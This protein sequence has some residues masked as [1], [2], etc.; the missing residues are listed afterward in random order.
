MPPFRL[1]LPVSLIA[2]ASRAGRLSVAGFLC[3]VSLAAA[4]QHDRVLAQ[5]TP[6]ARTQL[7]DLATLA[8]DELARLSKAAD[9]VAIEAE[10]RA[11]LATD[12]LNLAVRA[13]GDDGRA[14]VH[15]EIIRRLETLA[16]H[17]VEWVGSLRGRVPAPVPLDRLLDDA[18]R[19]APASID[20]AGE[21]FALSTLWANGPMP[22]LAPRGGLTGPLLDAGNG[23]WPSLDGL[24]LPG[25]IAL[26]DF[27]GGRNWERLF[28]LGAQAVIVIE[29]DFV[30]RDTAERLFAH[31]P[32]PC[33]RYYVDRRTGERLRQLARS[34]R[35]AATVSG[36]ARFES[37][38]WETMFAYLPPTSPTRHTVA[39]GEL[40]HRIATDFGL[41]GAQLAATAGMGKAAQDLSEGRVINVPGRKIAYT[42]R[43]GDLWTRLAARYG[44]STEALRRANPSAPERLPA[45]TTL[46]IPNVEATVTLVVPIDAMSVATDAEHGAL[47]AANLSAA[48]RF[49]EHLA[50]ESRTPRRKGLLVV[51]Q[52]ADT[53]GGV[54]SRTLAEY[55]LLDAG[56]FEPSPLQQTAAHVEQLDRAL[57]WFNAPDNASA[58][59][60]LRELTP[61]Q[62]RW[63]AETWLSQRLEEQ[64]VTLAEARIAGL[65]ARR[66]VQPSGESAGIAPG[67]SATNNALRALVQVR[68]ETL[69]AA[70]GTLAERLA[71]FRL[72]LVNTTWPAASGVP[73]FTWAR[74]GRRLAREHADESYRVLVHQNN[75]RVAH[76]VLARLHPGRERASDRA[77]LGWFLDLTDGS[78]TLG[79]THGR[80][81]EFRGAH[82]AATNPGTVRSFETRFSQLAAA[83][84]VRAGWNEEWLFATDDD[85]RDFPHLP[86]VSPA[87]YPDLWTAAGVALLSLGTLNDRLPRLD[88]PHDVPDR[89]DFTALARQAR[90]A[91]VLLQAGLERPADSLAPARL[92]R[93]RFG[94]L[95]GRALQFNVRSGID[96]TEPVPDA[97]VYYPAV[98]QVEAGPAF[99]TSTHRGYRRGVMA[100][101]SEEGAYRL[102]VESTSYR[103][104]NHVYA[105]KLDRDDG[106]FTQ[107]LNH[108]QTGA[109][110]QDFTFR[111]QADRETTKN[112]VLANLRP[113]AIFADNDPF[114]YRVIGGE[115]DRKVRHSVRLTDAVL[116]G[117]PPR[118]AVENPSLHFNERDLATTLLYAPAGRSLRAVVQEKT[119]FKLLLTGPVTAGLGEGYRVGPL[120]EGAAPPYPGS[121]R[122]VSRP[123]TVL[124]T[125]RDFLAMS[126]HRL[127]VYRTHGITSRSVE[128][129]V[130]RAEAKVQ[131]AEASV[132]QND[133]VGATGAAREAWGILIK[134]YPRLLSLGREAVFSVIVLMA[135]LLPACVFL[136]RLLLAGRGIVRQLCGV[137]GLFLAGTLFLNAFH[138]GFRV[139][140]S[141]F[142]VV[143]AFTMILM[144]GLV[145]SLCYRRFKVVLRRVRQQAGDGADDGASPAGAGQTALSLG[146]ANLRKRP[147]RTALTTFTVTVLTFSIVSFVSITGRDTLRFRA[148]PADPDI[149]GR[150]VQPERPAYDGVLFRK[151]N[152]FEYGTQDIA[153]MRSEFSGS[154]QVTTRGFYL[155]TEGGANA[156][157]EGVNQIPVSHGAAGVVLTGVMTFEPNEPAFSGL[158]RAV[159]DGAWFSERDRF[160]VILPAEAASELGITRDQLVDDMG[161]RRPEATL[162]TVHF[163]NLDWRVVGILDTDHA[164]RIRDVNGKSLAL[165]DHLRSAMTRNATGDSLLTEAPSVHLSWSR[166]LIVPQSAADAI[167]ARPRAIAVK[168]GDGTDRERFLEDLALRLNNGFFVHSHGRLGLLA[169]TEERDIAGLTKVLVPV[170]LCGL[171][172]LNTMMGAVEDRK[173]EVGM[174][175]AIGLSPRQ[176]SLLLLSESAVFSVLG[177]VLGLFAGLG[178]ANLVPW[179]ETQGFEGFAGLSF[180]FT[181]LTALSLALATGGVVLLATLIPARHAAALAAPSGMTAWKLP[182][183]DASGRIVFEL[184]FTLNR[185]NSAGM[186]AFL[187]QFLRNHS[188]ATS[189]DFVC[190]DVRLEAAPAGGTTIRCRLWPAPYDLDVAQDFAMHLQPSQTEGIDRVTL[191]L[192]RRSGTEEAWIRTTYAFLHLIRQQFLF[193][194][195]LPPDLRTKYIATGR[196]GAERTRT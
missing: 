49:L 128:Q 107:V 149:E 78:G 162:P 57:A 119:L 24:P 6:G 22:S 45:G 101:T 157:M 135:L 165:V 50:R 132:A 186:T 8:P 80:A 193:W 194:R 105:Y 126:K 111:L 72:R 97:A 48:L 151:Y 91:F 77:Q 146:L 34:H 38:P 15:R 67:P 10:T 150:T 117:E 130:T 39:P 65:T 175:G 52:D 42:V 89:T 137:S 63:L 20:V 121:E 17:G 41:T 18:H 138:P 179:L 75:L 7:G 53:L 56:L 100:L 154:H 46:T 118:Y 11:L 35:P 85:R 86:V 102:P 129:A 133:W 37:R 88:T 103:S 114:S 55:A 140:A 182:A 19:E 83:A 66:A 160:H 173:D 152:W 174:L 195:N 120:P 33:P 172:V 96:A 76:A 185:D 139:A 68:D 110:R 82:P 168:F 93:P 176:I 70:R 36:G 32:V 62:A 5:L 163:L 47:R 40:L 184:P 147:S 16:P 187:H 29:D 27:Q 136:E 124:D 109:R 153:T 148:Q 112:L 142:I 155:D 145:L 104:L 64:R 169:P 192:E 71:A 54:G 166:L 108:G 43:R 61:P 51:F 115:R 156:D 28:S 113:L 44:V 161:R 180:N 95:T 25:A 94:Q 30:T 144:S 143:I 181:S 21:R 73:N 74:L 2:R 125:A 158:N 60:A 31:T 4:P 106:V 69:G 9:P 167:N 134:T 188:D 99:N 170:L 59:A 131:E 127:D 98:K 123:L 122:N 3:A 58:D 141:P 26:M 190:R 84:A 13:P 14:A 87:A 189:G 159:S 164:D 178:V 196:A 177:I 116:Q 171:I 81:V 191:H 12:S 90:T 1:H 92:P 23:D 79:L 183:P